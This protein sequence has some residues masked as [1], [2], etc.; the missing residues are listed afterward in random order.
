MRRR[1]SPLAVALSACATGIGS[2]ASGAPSLVGEWVDVAHTTVRDSMTWILDADGEER[3]LRRRV[4][5]ATDG[6][7][8]IVTEQHFYAHWHLEG[9]LG[10]PIRRALC[11]DI[12][13]GRFPPTC[14]EFSL[15]TV[16]VAGAKHRRIV[17]LRFPDTHVSVDRV[18]L[19]R[20]PLESHSSGVPTSQRLDGYGCE[21][22]TSAMQRLESRRAALP[23]GPCIQ[24]CT[25]LS[26]RRCRVIDSYNSFSSR[27]VNSSWS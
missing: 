7:E 21:R 22:G 18:L 4:G 3:H 25:V 6:T 13:R 12:R 15:D 8:S 16:L 14:Y 2:A 5:V 10:D 9:S 27:Y 17:L 24:R 20:A 23:S 26:C 1:W 19:E 11:F